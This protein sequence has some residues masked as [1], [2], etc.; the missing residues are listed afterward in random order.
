MSDPSVILRQYLPVDYTMGVGEE[1]FA[2]TVEE[3]TKILTLKLRIRLTK[4][5]N[6]P[7]ITASVLDD[8]ETSYLTL[9]ANESGKDN[10]ISITENGQDLV[11]PPYDPKA[12][13]R[14]QIPRS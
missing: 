8:G 6:N 14:Q 12:M 7:G 1:E 4:T 3:G 5:Q 10:Q 11:I 9:T 13:I 2:F